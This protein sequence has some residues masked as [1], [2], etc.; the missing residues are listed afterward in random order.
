MG[1]KVLEK[2]LINRMMHHLYG[3]NLMNP[4]QYGFIPKKYRRRHTS[5]ERIHRRRIQTRTHYYTHKLRRTGGFRRGMV[6]EYITQPKNYSTA[7]KT[8]IILPEANLAVGQQP[9]IPT[10]FKLKETSPRAALRAHAAA[11]TFGT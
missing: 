7:R 1:G 9:N 10:V 11:P 6:A 2:L 5:S 3:N 4:N 8:Y